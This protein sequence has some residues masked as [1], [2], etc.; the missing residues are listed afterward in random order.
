MMPGA[1]WKMSASSG[2]TLRKLTFGSD[3]ARGILLGWEGM[4]GMAA[5]RGDGD[6]LS[7]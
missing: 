5:S 3:E 4:P 7:A 2:G 1:M 6:L